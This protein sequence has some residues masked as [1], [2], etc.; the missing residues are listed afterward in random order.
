MHTRMVSTQLL[1]QHRRLRRRLPDL[2]RLARP[3][4][5]TTVRDAARQ[6][7]EILDRE[8]LAHA[9]LEDAVVDAAPAMRPTDAGRLRPC[10]DSLRE[11]TWRLRS[12]AEGDQPSL[13]V[14]GLIGAVR[15]LLAVH[16][17]DEWRT[18]APLLGQLDERRAAALAALLPDHRGPGERELRAILPVSFD[19]VLAALTAPHRALECAL[20]AA[21]EGAVSRAARGDAV[22]CRPHV[23]L[24]LAVTGPRLLLLAGRLTLAGLPEPGSVQEFDAAFSPRRDGVTDLAIH[25]ASP[26]QPRRHP[27]DDRAVTAVAALAGALGAIAAGR[28]P[29]VPT[30]VHPTGR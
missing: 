2:A 6:A 16:L 12:R 5:E 15:D 14:P 29:P 8:V 26:S 11:A 23:E 30:T 28:R 3:A 17:E 13:A 25:H 27:H 9:D 7:I 4:D 21:A 24:V 19:A 20:A 10:H 18:L 22:V 1:R